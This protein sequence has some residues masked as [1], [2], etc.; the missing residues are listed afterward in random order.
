MQN[1]GDKV[2]RGAIWSIYERFG[3]L[4]IQFVAN[5]I[6]ARLLT[7]TDFGIIGI[8]LIFVSVANVLADSGLGAALVQ[9]K[10]LLKEDC[11]TIFY[12][13][14][15]I[16]TILYCLIYIAA[17]LINVFFNYDNLTLYLRCICV[18]VLIDSVGSIQNS[19]INR[20]LDFKSIAIL[21]NIAALIACIVSIYLAYHGFGV[22]A[23]IIQYIIFSIMR[24]ILLYIFS[25]W[26]PSLIF[27]M[28]SL[29]T[30]FG[31]GSKLMLS[32]FIAELY[33]NF[34]TFLIGKFL[35]PS[36]L[37]YYT[38]AKQLQQVPVSALTSIVN[39]VSFPAFSK[40]QDERDRFVNAYKHNLILLAAI[41]FPLM[42]LLSAI[43]K[44][45]I[46]VLYSDK[47]IDSV[48]LF[49]L[50]CIGFGALLAIHNTNLTVLKAL[51]KSNEVLKL[52]I[53]KKIIGVVLM[54]FGILTFGIWGVMFALALNS[55]IEL[56]LNGNY[57][58]KNISINISSQIRF[59]LPYLSFSIIAFVV[60]IAIINILNA[61][62]IFL[63]LIGAAVFSIIYCCLVFFA[64]K[65]AF[66]EVFLPILKRLKIVR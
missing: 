61:S 27:S 65:R 12:T 55:I 46:I 48:P 29:K 2:I 5:L 4:G 62:N 39:Q 9:K 25:K 54:T 52:E 33:L 41:N 20:N 57:I 14:I 51:G 23:L 10:E 31:F 13:N 32:T 47:W 56:F 6:M 45:L 38:Q 44:P 40:L 36:I 26:R 18:I 64:E 37:G 28:E 30:L 24:T 19:L 60:S 34:Q 63:L 42:F 58:Y 43:A 53:I 11:S 15:L 17:P 50:L 66:H 3:Y 59:I 22:W 35:N 8:L 49:Q 21:K 1:L 7:P 16:A